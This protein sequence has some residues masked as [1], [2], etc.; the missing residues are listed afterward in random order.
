[1]CFISFFV[2][3][4]MQFQ[5][6]TQWLFW[7]LLVLMVVIEI[8]IFCSQFGRKHPVNLIL[9][10]MFTLCESYFVSFIC[11]MTAMQSGTQV[12]VVAAVMTFGTRALTQQSSCLSPFMRSSLAQTSP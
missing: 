11:A 4:F 9:L 1:M 12:V 8:F 10:I 5:Y 3:A 2:P 6:N 7:V